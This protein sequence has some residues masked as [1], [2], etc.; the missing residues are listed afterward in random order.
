LAGLSIAGGGGVSVVGGGAISINSVGGVLID[1][2]G[3]ISI[4]GIGGISIVG[5]G[6]LAIAAG[7]ILVSGGGIVVSAGGLGIT[8]GGLSVASGVMA[9]GSAG[10]AGGGV[11][12]YGSDLTMLPVGPTQ[13][14]LRTNFIASQTGTDV[15]AIS[16][17]A[18]I[19]G[20]PYPPTGSGVKSERATNTTPINI[21]ATTFGTAQTILTMTI[22]PTFISD[23]NANVS[24]HYQT[25]S[26]TN[27]NLIF[28][29][30]LDGVQIGTTTA[31]TV[32]GVSH[33]SNCAIVGSG[34]NQSVG[35]HTVLLKAYAGSA[36]ASG[37]LTVI[38]SS[39]YVMANLV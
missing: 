11:N 7:G 19:N 15:L 13:S 33:F 24:F 22:T 30:T 25:N 28:Y 29:L 20:A 4:N 37:N 17:V 14:T 2:G 32:G 36:P 21:T 9:I 8:A 5:S 6:A 27:Y 16:N 18:T 10:L 35:L 3:A 39:G 12:I 26:N 31:D 23:I 1:G 34:L 38:A